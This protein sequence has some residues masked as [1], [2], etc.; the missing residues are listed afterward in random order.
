M[1]RGQGK[2][3]YFIGG[4]FW[5]CKP[6]A[7]LIFFLACPLICLPVPLFDPKRKI[8]AKDIEKELKG[9]EE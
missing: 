5:I 2:G 9:K 7:G 3:L 4:G 8:T 6:F 1:E